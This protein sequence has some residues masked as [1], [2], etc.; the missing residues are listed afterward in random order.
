[1]TDYDTDFVAWIDEQAAQLRARATNALDWDNLAE[2]IESMGR[3]QRQEVRSRLKRICQH[4]LK[5][6][7][8][9]D[10]RSR[11]WQ[12]TIEMQRDDLEEV[13]LDSPSLRFYAATQLTKV[14]KAGRKVA[15]NET[16]IE[17]LP[18]VCPWTIEQIIDP[19]FW[20]GDG[21]L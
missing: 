8:Q 3:S 20:P 12:T 16:G 17:S 14:Y 21:D 2:E 15:V 13:L 5:W 10:G 6:Q 19:E 7:Y 1:M 4:L 11:S 9:R 18:E